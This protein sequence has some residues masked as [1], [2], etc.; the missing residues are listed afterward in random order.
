MPAPGIIKLDRRLEEQ[1]T[2]GRRLASI[3]VVVKVTVGD[4]SLT[5]IL[6]RPRRGQLR[7]NRGWLW[8]L[9]LNVVIL[10]SSHCR[11]LHKASTVLVPSAV[12]MGACAS[13]GVRNSY[14][15]PWVT[16]SDISG[17]E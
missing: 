4:A 15:S 5:L 9:A 13:A 12:L 3:L 7:S 1:R 10:P 17:S 6:R 2:S 11:L 14:S 8:L 16:N